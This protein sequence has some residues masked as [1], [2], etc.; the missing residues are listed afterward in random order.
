[1]FNVSN[2]IVSEKTRNVKTGHSGLM[3]NQDSHSDPRN[4]NAH[5]HH[6]INSSSCKRNRYFD[7]GYWQRNVMD[8]IPHENFDWTSSS[9]LLSSSVAKKRQLHFT[10]LQTVISDNKKM[11]AR[12]DPFADLESRFVAEEK[13][14]QDSRITK[15]VQRSRNI[16]YDEFKFRSLGHKQFSRLSED[17]FYRSAI[18]NLPE[19]LII[20]RY[21]ALCKRAA[22]GDAAR[23]SM[24]SIINS[25]SD[26]DEPELTA[27]ATVFNNCFLENRTLRLVWLPMLTQ[28]RMTRALHMETT[29]FHTFEP[30]MKS[31]KSNIEIEPTPDSSKTVRQ[32]AKTNNSQKQRDE[33]RNHCVAEPVIHDDRNFAFMSRRN[34]FDETRGVN[35]DSCCQ[36]SLDEKQ[37]IHYW[38]VAERCL[39]FEFH[40]NDL[41]HILKMAVENENMQSK[42][43][44]QFFVQ[45]FGRENVY[46]RNMPKLATIL[47]IHNKR[48]NCKTFPSAMLKMSV[49][50]LVAFVRRNWS[51]R[52]FRRN[53][54][55][56][57]LQLLEAF[58]VSASIDEIAD[59]SD[60][61]S[62]FCHQTEG[63]SAETEYLMRKSSD[64]IDSSSIRKNVRPGKKLRKKMGMK[65]KTRG[66]KTTS[67]NSGGKNVYL[68][69]N[70]KLN[71][72]LGLEILDAFLA[73]KGEQFPELVRNEYLFW[74]DKLHIPDIK[75]VH[76]WS[77]VNLED[78]KQ[79]RMKNKMDCCTSNHYKSL[80]TKYDYFITPLWNQLTPFV[81][82]WAFEGKV[83]NNVMS[84]CVFEKLHRL[85]NKVPKLDVDRRRQKKEEIFQKMKMCLQPRSGETELS[86]NVRFIK[87]MTH[88]ES[89]LFKAIK[90]QT[91]FESLSEI[92]SNDENINFVTALSLLKK[93]LSHL[94]L[95]KMHS[96]KCPDDELLSDGPS[97]V[98]SC[99][100][101][102][103][104]ERPIDSFFPFTCDLDKT[105]CQMELRNRFVYQISDGGADDDDLL[106]DLL[107]TSPFWREKIESM[108]FNVMWICNLL[109][110]MTAIHLQEKKKF[111][112]TRKRRAP[113]SRTSS[114]NYRFDRCEQHQLQNKNEFHENNSFFVLVCSVMNSFFQST[115]TVDDHFSD[116]ENCRSLSMAPWSFVNVVCLKYMHASLKSIF[117]E[118]LET[119]CFDSDLFAELLV[120][121]QHFRQRPVR[122][123]VLRIAG[124]VSDVETRSVCRALVCLMLCSHFCLK[125]NCNF[126]DSIL[127][128][129]CATIL[130]GR[131]LEPISSLPLR[132]GTELGFG[133]SIDI[134]EFLSSKCSAIIDNNIG[135]ECLKYS[136]CIKEMFV[137]DNEVWHRIEIF[138]RLF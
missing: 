118:N 136:R 93:Q 30:I 92:F 117:N 103:E 108:R 8:R 55:F 11:R 14:I 17:P 41:S 94:S 70:D 66:S 2:Q 137:N 43:L 39:I 6:H 109:L 81:K 10:V 96:P 128:E 89:V 24:L 26:T 9:S 113:P 32:Q 111:K 123:D 57:A 67:F 16:L 49:A 37:A 73:G 51:M 44:V 52:V 40:V 120:E 27:N 12:F 18:R 85:L 76:Q 42:T 69:D 58:I 106:L 87:E 77:I 1:M 13:I 64:A 127:L 78:L 110:P 116:W 46:K 59:N 119:T 31:M 23:N 20:C 97:L 7:E 65:W 134:F 107:V 121:S 19:R 5:P 38:Y 132:N 36:Y 54:Q 126:I 90:S 56:L 99:P 82:T 98:Q 60:R 83:F 101:A 138:Q 105:L 100:V 68:F 15:Y 74:K 122:S 4:L 75:L 22:D 61:F 104:S 34:Q 72:V 45:R 28:L 91:S 84:W 102:S 21:Y 114:P 63:I 135:E 88:V 130:V 133:Q 112:A 115:T 71:L 35:C 50:T 53:R 48:K 80:Q 124:N 79:L 33:R 3:K 29:G 25:F 62:N 86:N 95:S 129:K 125:N 47:S 131:Y